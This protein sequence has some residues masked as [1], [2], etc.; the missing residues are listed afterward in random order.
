MNILLVD[1]IDFIINGLVTSKMANNER[2]PG[3]YGS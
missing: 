3:E 1:S 2:I